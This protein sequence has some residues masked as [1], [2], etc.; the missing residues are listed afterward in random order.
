MHFSQ[1]QLE[2]LTITAM[3]I[4]VVMSSLWKICSRIV[5]TDRCHFKIWN[6]W[7]M[8]SKNVPIYTTKMLSWRMKHL[9]ENQ[10][11]QYSQT[12]G[13]SSNENMCP[14]YPECH[15]LCVCGEMWNEW[16]RFHWWQ[17]SSCCLALPPRHCTT[18]THRKSAYSSKWL[19]YS[20]LYFLLLRPD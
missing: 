7:G 12:D 10:F 17:F 2:L 4:S 18:A 11:Y 20:N 13:L 1:N 3:I 15:L 14:L 8:F 5:N 19:G 9:H 6:H 16:S